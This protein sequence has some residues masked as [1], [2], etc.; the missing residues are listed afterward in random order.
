MLTIAIKNHDIPFR[1]T[2]TFTN[3]L[4][5]WLP[6]KKLLRLIYKHAMFEKTD[7]SNKWLYFLVVYADDFQIEGGMWPTGKWQSNTKERVEEQ[8]KIS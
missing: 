5:K 6:Y 7:A 8:K 1:K 3:W 4:N 2:T